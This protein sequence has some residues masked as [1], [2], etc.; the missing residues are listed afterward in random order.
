M[1]VGRQDAPLLPLLLPLLGVLVPG[2]L[3][4]L[5]VG[6]ACLLLLFALQVQG[7]PVDRAAINVA[8]H[9]FELATHALHRVSKK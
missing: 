4:L 9:R 1:N 2:L 6:H 5:L 3:F 7:A 8:L